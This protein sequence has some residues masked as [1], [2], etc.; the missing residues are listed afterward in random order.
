M[1]IA[2][3]TQVIFVHRLAFSG[4]YLLQH[5][6]QNNILL[7]TIKFKTFQDYVLCK[8]QRFQGLEFGTIKS[9][10]FQDFQGPIRTLCMVLMNQDIFCLMNKLLYAMTVKLKAG[11]CHSNVA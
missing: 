6:S 10:A 3:C 1:L 5:L 7:T 8:I 4:C 2:Q 9:K 11:C